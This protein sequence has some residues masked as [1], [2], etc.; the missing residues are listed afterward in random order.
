M[1]STQSI[2]VDLSNPYISPA[3][4][5]YAKQGD[6][7]TRVVSLTITDN[8]KKVNV[9][10]STP[11]RVYFGGIK[12]NSSCYITGIMSTGTIE[13]SI[14]QSALLKSGTVPAEIQIYDTDDGSKVIA[15]MT[16]SVI[17]KPCVFSSSAEE[18][19]NSDID[20]LFDRTIKAVTTSAEKVPDEMF[21]NCTNL[22]YF[23]G[24]N[25]KE[26]GKNAFNGCKALNNI[27]LSANTDMMTGVLHIPSGMAVYESA[28][29]G[30][31]SIKK[32]IIDEGVTFDGGSHFTLVGAQ[33]VKLPSD[34]TEIKTYMFRY[35]PAKVLELPESV[36]RLREQCF[37]Y[38]YIEKLIIRHT[39]EVISIASSA[40]LWDSAISKGN[41]Y[42]YVPDALIDSYKTADNWKSYA[43]QFKKLSEL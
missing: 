14:P 4:V 40:V 36:V 22:S 20:R 35:L 31:T 8:G 23:N 42:I 41:G 28:F 6:S 38:S 33:S 43:S 3:P 37:R 13:F 19:T 24:V 12:G 29:S 39:G 15:T 25:V 18:V 27:R 16:F 32:I 5:I 26:I 10:A 11:Y 17:V 30:C 7:K 21:K 9:D 34:M 2:T 1:T